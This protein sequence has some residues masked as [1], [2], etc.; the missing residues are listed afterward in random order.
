M[1][2]RKSKIRGVV[3][4]GMLCSA[5]ELGLGEESDGIIE[6]PDDAPVG[7]S[8]VEFLGLP[9]AVIDV[10]LTPNRGDCFSV[11]GIA[12]DVAAMTGADLQDANQSWRRL[13]QRLTTSIRSNLRTGGHARDSP[14]ELLRALTRRRSRR[15][16][17]LNACAGVDSEVFTRSSTYTNYVMLELGQPLHAYDL[18]AL[19]GAD[20]PAIR[21]GKVKKSRLLDEKEVELTDDTLVIIATTA[22]P[23][24]TG[25]RHGRPEHAVDDDYRHVSLKRHSGHR[26]FMAGRAR[27]YG[28]HTDASM[29]FERGVDPSRPGSCNQA[30]RRAV[31]AISGGQAGPPD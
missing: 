1:K 27:S 11:L 10:D 13:L 30:R 14:V 15:S 2:L 28:M 6:L 25:R 20:Q 16:G 23:I 21:N 5:V 31:A 22:G 7:E 9:D 26:P 8:L 19:Q 24:G 29:R 3:S 17:W 4:N 18:A 12:R